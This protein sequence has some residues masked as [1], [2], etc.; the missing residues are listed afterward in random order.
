ML[1]SAKLWVRPKYQE[2]EVL[3]ALGITRKKEG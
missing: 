1:S 3:K 2:E